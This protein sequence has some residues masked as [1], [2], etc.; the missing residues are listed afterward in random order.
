MT[1]WDSLAGERGLLW[2]EL[3]D[4]DPDSA[5]VRVMP[6]GAAFVMVDSRYIASRGAP[7]HPNMT[8]PSGKDA[9]AF[10]PGR[11]Q[12]RANPAL[13]AGIPA[14][15]YTELEW[16]LL[17]T[18][19]AKDGMQ[20]EF[21]VTRAGVAFDTYSVTPKLTVG[22]Q[23]AFDGALMAAMDRPWRDLVQDVVRVVASGMTP[24]ALVKP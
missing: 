8:P 20:Y 13:P 16:A 24:P 2:N 9:A 10:A 18:T 1:L 11:I 4:K 22:T 5:G 3:L 17:I 12:D 14:D 19:A 15:D 7:T 6:R 23:A 21:R